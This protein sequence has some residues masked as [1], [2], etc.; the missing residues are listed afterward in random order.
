[1]E[2]RERERGGRGRGRGGEGVEASS[3]EAGRAPGRHYLLASSDCT[4]PFAG[5][6]SHR[7]IADSSRSLAR[8]AARVE[9]GPE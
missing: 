8:L 5:V 7:P 6:L 2:E 1:M 3:A 9:S 4:A